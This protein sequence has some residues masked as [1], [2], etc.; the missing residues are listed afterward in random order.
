MLQNIVIE[1]FAIIDQV[2]IDFDEG[3]TVLTGE[4]GAGKSIIIDALGLLAG[5]RG[6]VDFI[7]YGTKSLKLRGIF[8][9]PDFSQAGRD[10]LKD[11]E[12]PFEDDQLLITRTLDQKGRNTIKV[13][14]VPLTVS[15]LKEL[16]DYLLEIHGQ[17]E[18]QSLL[19]PKNHLDL[20]DQYAGKRIV[21]EKEDYEKDYQNYREAKKAIKDFALN[22]QEVAQR[23]DLLKFQLNEIELAQLVEGE[24]EELTEERQKLQSYQNIVA[25][26]GQA[27][28]ALSEGEGNAVDLLS[29]SSQALGQIEDLD[30]DYKAYYEQAQ[31]AYYSVQELAYS[32]R[33]NLDALSYDPRRLDQIEERLA[34]I[35]QLKHKYGKS[36]AEILAYYQE[37]QKDYQ[38]LQ[39]RENHQEELEADFK[40]AKQAIAKSAKALHQKRLTVA[41]E[42]EAAIEEQLA[43]LY[44][45]NTRFAVD[46]KQRKSFAASGADEVTFYIQTN[47]GE[48]LRPLHKIASG[49][50]L[51]RIIL[52]IKAIL[53]ASRPTSTVVFDEVDT[54]VSGRVAQAIANKMFEIALSAQVLCI[55]HLSQVAAMADQQLHIAKVSDK[56]Q[57]Q[58]Q[59]S[60]LNEEERIGEIGHMTTGEIMTEASRRAAQDQLK[61]AQDY[62]QQRRQDIHED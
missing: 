6:S 34:T 25:S 52:A 19:D 4:T 2:T 58:T 36:I 21:Q 60:R 50:E 37:A 53:Q 23:L 41:E 16:G 14:G 51:S 48:P 8:Y 32:I 43:D 45:K 22:E 29:E 46:F 56:D 55:S 13:N 49:G 44:M 47:P 30:S 33:D 57:T 15:L 18:H 20:L 5:G 10:F 26:L 54:G 61:Q 28:N 62:R 42:L 38:D 3:M 27:L 39:D 12:I 7:R 1:N 35:D 11:Q 31:S 59:V 40:Q 24:D 9:L 17:N